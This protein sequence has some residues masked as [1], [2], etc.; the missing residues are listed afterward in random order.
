LERSLHALRSK[1]ISMI[2]GEGQLMG[3]SNI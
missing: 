2:A 1:V 3:S